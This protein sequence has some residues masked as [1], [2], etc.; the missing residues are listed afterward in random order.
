MSFVEG[1]HNNGRKIIIVGYCM[2]FSETSLTIE[3][4]GVT[5]HIHSIRQYIG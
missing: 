5:L 4:H 2:C 3:F 1:M